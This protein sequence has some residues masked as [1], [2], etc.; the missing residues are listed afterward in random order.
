IPKKRSR[1]GT[2][3]THAIGNFSLQTRALSTMGTATRVWRCLG[4]FC[5]RS[6]MRTPSTGCQGLWENHRTVERAAEAYLELQP[7]IQLRREGVVTTFELEN[8]IV[9]GEK[10]CIYAGFCKA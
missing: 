8:V 4:P 3:R 9:L 10:K 6:S 7:S 1:S 5:A 2:A